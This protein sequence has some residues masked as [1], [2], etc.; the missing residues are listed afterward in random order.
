MTPD[1]PQA[2]PAPSDFDGPTTPPDDTEAAPPPSIERPTHIGP[3]KILE[4]IGE[5]GMGSVYRAEQQKPVR[6]RVALKVIKLGMDSKEVLA[7]FEAERQAL[8]LMNHP[9]IAAVFD[10]GVTSNGQSYFSMEHVPGVPITEY[11]DRQ[12]LATEERL[13][14]FMKVCDGVQ[15]AHQKGIIHRDIKPSNILVRTDGE[16]HVPKIIDFGIAKATNQRLTE[17]TIFTEQGQLIGTPEYMSPEQA[18]MTAEDIDT[19]SDVYSLGVLLYELLVGELPFDPQSLRQ[20]SYAEIQRIIREVDPP[21][22]STRLMTLGDDSTVTAR[23]RRTDTRTLLRRLRGD[24]DWITMKALEKNRARRYESAAQLAEDITRHL[25][26]EPILARAPSTAYRLQKLC[27][28]HKLGVIAGGSVLIALVVGIIGTTSMMLRALRAEQ[29]AKAKGETAT[30]VTDFL[31]RDVL[32]EFDPVKGADTILDVL[33]RTAPRIDE[34]FADQPE[35]QARLHLTFGRAFLLRIRYQ[36]AEDHLDRAIE[37]NEALFGPD[38]LEVASPLAYKAEVYLR[39]KSPTQRLSHRKDVEEGIRIMRRV[40]AIRLRILG[41]DDSQTVTAHGDIARYEAVLKGMPSA[42]LT[43]TP[44]LHALALGRGKGETAETI[45]Q[46]LERL[47]VETEAGWAAG[48]RRELFP[49]IIEFAQPLL[50]KPLLR[51]RVPLGL[52]GFAQTIYRQGYHNAAEA[53]ATV[54][55]EIGINDLGETHRY[56]LWAH[57]V[58]G[59]IQNKRGRPRDALAT[60]RTALPQV[61]RA[62]GEKHEYYLRALGLVG[63]T[64]LS[65]GLYKEAASTLT[66]AVE[67]AT[68]LEDSLA[69]G[70]YLGLKG[71]CLVELG[72]YRDAEALLLESYAVLTT[73]E[74]EPPSKASTQ[75]AAT[76]VE[77]Y[78]RTNDAESQ[79][80]WQRRAS[81]RAEPRD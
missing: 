72:E 81:L 55:V 66:A 32:G 26:H 39:R 21:K 17:R 47:L 15:H 34:Q 14:L 80:L 58:L 76:L 54:S 2:T 59:G 22:P 12:R 57:Q 79:A 56:T 63:A 24:L 6:R 18:E 16:T 31:D 65:I 11:C 33:E 74:G 8:A 19:R 10:A 51:E 71:S 62:F 45:R 1:D 61:R 52:S 53:L 25:R 7:R 36:L 75:T 41:P 50:D 69:R 35:V 38:T 44:F 30:A 64:E 68:D 67:V 70:R 48:K 40:H 4:L 27:Q 28:R 77:L 3:Y 43:S 13:R 20:A 46:T 49:P 23:K 37:L 5:G 9:N 42:D 73:Q 29:E 78:H 60:Y